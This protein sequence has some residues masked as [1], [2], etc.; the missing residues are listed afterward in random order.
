MK[1]PILFIMEIWKDIN[2]Y[3]WQYQISNLWKV[4]SFKSWKEK[5]MKLWIW[6]RW[7]TY[8]ILSLNWIRSLIST[9]RLVAIH[10]IQNPLNLPCA[11]HKIEEL[12][13]NWA[14]YNWEDNLFWGTQKDNMQ[15]CALKW[16][17]S[18]FHK[19]KFWKYHPT[20]RK[21]N[22]YTKEGV[23]I[24]TWD[25]MMDVQRELWIDQ[26]SICKTCNWKE[27]S[28]GWFIWKYIL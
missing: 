11:C 22:Q 24:K 28:S 10:F 20:S 5:I 19:W 4:K 27:K 23:F 7:H 9:H 18:K 13:E 6:K 16:R 15:D 26:S 25:S 17:A 12:D 2:W 1:P 3:W 21:I 14:L 8:I